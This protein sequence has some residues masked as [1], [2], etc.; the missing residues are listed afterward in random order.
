[1]TTPQPL[2]SLIGQGGLEL[3]VAYCVGGVLSPLLA[4]IALSVLDEHFAAR[5]AAPGPEWKRVKHRRAG[6]AV[7][8]LVRYA[9]DF[10]VMVAGQRADAEALRDQV[11]SVLAPMGLR[12]SEAKTRV[13]TSTRGSTS[14]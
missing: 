9:D 7:M 6:G 3:E 13:A 10:V 8:K 4:N 14:W 2:S 12:L 1:M 5:W 11:S